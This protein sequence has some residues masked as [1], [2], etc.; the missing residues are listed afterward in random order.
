MCNPASSISDFYP[1]EF[2]LDLNGKRY[3]WQAVVLLP[4]IDE[5]TPFCLIAM[6]TISRF[7]A[8]LVVYRSLA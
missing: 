6:D 5:R 3:A 4:F 1:S 8:C 7:I 2:N